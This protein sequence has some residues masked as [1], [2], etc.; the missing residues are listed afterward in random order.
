M[1]NVLCTLV[2]DSVAH[3]I[4]TL[5]TPSGMARNKTEASTRAQEKVALQSEVMPEEKRSKCSNKRLR[6]AR[7]QEAEGV[8]ENISQLL[9]VRLFTVRRP[10]EQCL[11]FSCTP[12]PSGVA[13]PRCCA[14]PDRVCCPHYWRCPQGCA[15]SWVLFVDLVKAFDSVPLDVLF[16]VLAKFGGVSVI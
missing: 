5:S 7:A 14:M 12:Q 11:P 2:I 1:V 6:E 16:T 13:W 10:N 9:L 8:L 3:H 4:D 15:L